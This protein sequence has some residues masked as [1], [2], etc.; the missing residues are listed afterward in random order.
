MGNGGEYIS[1]WPRSQAWR[2]PITSGSD[3]LESIPQS[4]AAKHAEDGRAC[5]AGTRGYS[6]A[7]AA[8]DARKGAWLTAWPAGESCGI[9]SKPMSTP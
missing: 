4:S 9:P 2:D 6:A 7:E 5:E 1:A 8:E 3:E